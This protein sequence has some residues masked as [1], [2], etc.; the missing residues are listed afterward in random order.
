M[1]A[2]CNSGLA[3]NA[4]ISRRIYVTIRPI[5][6]PESP[7]MANFQVILLLFLASSGIALLF[8]GVLMSMLV[9]FGNK[10]YGYGI[11]QLLFFPVAIVYCAIYRKERASYAARLVFG[12][13]ALLAV[14]ALLGL[15]FY[16]QDPVT[17]V[18]PAPSTH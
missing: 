6:S 1:I 13:L 9:A 8:V 4:T 7:R 14:G 16:H 12:G 11:A 17:K 5:N 3:P 10:Q 15:A 2:S 18:L